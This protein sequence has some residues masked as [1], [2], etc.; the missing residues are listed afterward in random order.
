MPRITRD[1]FISEDIVEVALSKAT[2]YAVGE[3]G[4][5]VVQVPIPK[6]MKETKTI[7]EEYAIG[8]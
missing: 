4:E 1:T 8:D 2:M 5:S 3:D 6:S 7:P